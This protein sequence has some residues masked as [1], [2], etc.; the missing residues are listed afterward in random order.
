MILHGE[1]IIGETERFLVIRRIEQD[2]TNTFRIWFKEREKGMKQNC[3]ENLLPGTVPGIDEICRRYE[4][5]SVACDAVE[6]SA[7]ACL[8]AY[9]TSI[10]L[11]IKDIANDPYMI[12]CEQT[13]SAAITRLQVLE[14]ETR[15]YFRKL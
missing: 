8:S 5:I 4:E 1:E 12:Q 11:G 2:G 3:E 9:D 15:R 13:L 7:L 14:I 10:M 6:A